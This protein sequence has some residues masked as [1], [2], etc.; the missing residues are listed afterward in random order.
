[1]GIGVIHFFVASCLGRSFLT[2]DSFF[3]SIGRFSQE[4]SEAQD[5]GFNGLR[6]PVALQKYINVPQEGHIHINR[7]S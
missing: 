1:M 7:D 3:K 6:W 2:A 4:G 5:T